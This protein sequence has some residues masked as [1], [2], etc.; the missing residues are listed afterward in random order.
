MCGYTLL[1]GWQVL[2]SSPGPVRVDWPQQGNGLPA[3]GHASGFFVTLVL[4]IVRFVI[5]Q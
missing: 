4:L 5:V 1:G 2:G 3:R